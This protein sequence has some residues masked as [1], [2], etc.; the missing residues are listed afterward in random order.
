[1]RKFTPLLVAL[2]VG[3]GTDTEPPAPSPTGPVT[4]EATDGGVTLTLT[5]ERNSYSADE[6][7]EV[8]ATLASAGEDARILF[9]SGHPVGF[10]VTRVEDGLTSGHPAFTLD[11]ASHEIGPEP[12]AYP[13]TK[14][15]GVEEEGPN[16]AFHRAYFFGGRALQLP[17]GTWRIEATT[18]L[19]AGPE[20]GGAPLDL[21][22]AIE[23]F[24]GD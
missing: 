17:A 11:C 2:L 18:S 14:S 23:V 9:G 7:I 20:C 6:E 19:T 8:G 24:V 1:M 22:T 21:A 13:F 4:S 10:S 3:C 16:A 12:V 5:A 15:G